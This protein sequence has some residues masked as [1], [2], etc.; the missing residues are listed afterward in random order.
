MNKVTVR[1][2]PAFSL[3]FWSGHV[4]LNDSFQRGGSY[5]CR[6]ASS[7]LT[8]LEVGGKQTG[9]QEMVRAAGAAEHRTHTAAE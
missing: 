3:S 4:E 2:Y 7:S 6:M 8:E 5:L 9:E 1:N